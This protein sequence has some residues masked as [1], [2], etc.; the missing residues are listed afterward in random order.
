MYAEK[1]FLRGDGLHFHN[2]FR[3]GLRNDQE[4]LRFGDNRIDL[5]F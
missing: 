4:I 1:I 5:Q 3:L 2:V